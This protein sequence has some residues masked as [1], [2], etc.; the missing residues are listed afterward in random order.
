MLH[1]PLSGRGLLAVA[2]FGLG[3]STVVAQEP[4]QSA[5]QG[6]VVVKDATTGELRAPTADEARALRQ[7]A[8]PAARTAALRASAMA[9][10]VAG[11]MTTSSGAIGY[12][13][14]ESY[15]SYSIVTRDANG[16]LVERC[17]T[18]ADAAEAALRAPASQG[19]ERYETQ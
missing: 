7:A 5:S 17:V 11:P 13:L 18:G 19:G 1:L 10:P 2:L 3:C 12:R 15:M 6:M 9:T 16:N 14:D 8:V 4:V